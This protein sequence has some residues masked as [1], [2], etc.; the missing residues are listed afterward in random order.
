MNTN[1]HSYG[2]GTYGQGAWKPPRKGPLGHVPVGPLAERTPDSEPTGGGIVQGQKA[3]DLEMRVYRALRRLGWTDET[4]DFQYAIGGGRQPG[5]QIVDFLLQNFGRTIAIAV[6]GDYWHNRTQQQKEDDR[7]KQAELFE[8]FRRPV[9]FVKLNSGDIVDEA[10][11]Y[12]R[13]LREVGAG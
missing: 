6:D 1:K 11:T 8:W 2:K 5:G 13:L 10:M 4:V 7:Q 9:Q 3:S 12:R